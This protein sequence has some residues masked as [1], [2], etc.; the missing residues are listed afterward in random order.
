MVGRI[1]VLALIARASFAGAGLD[2]L[3]RSFESPPEDSRMMMRWWWFGPAVTPDELERELRAMKEAGIGGVEIQ[4]VYPL[5]VDNA[6]SKLRNLP[7]LSPEFLEML[8]FAAGKAKELGLRADLTLGSGWP[9]GGPHISLAESAR[10]LRVEKLPGGA[11][12]EGE[13][14]VADFPDQGLRFIDS[15]LRMMVKR[16]SV[17]AEGLVLDHYSKA[18]TSK[19]LAVIGERLLSVLGP[20]PPYAVFCDS[21]EVFGSDWTPALLDEFQRRRGYDLR[22]LLPSLVGELNEESG[23]VRNDWAKTLAELAEENFLEVGEDW[24]RRHKTLWRVQVYGTPPVTLASQRLVDLADG[25]KAQWRQLTPSRWASS[26]NHILGRPVTATETWTWLHSPSFAATPLDMKAEADRHFLQGVNQLIGH[27]WPYSPQSTGKPGWSLY[28]AAVFNDSNPWWN[29]MPDVALYMRRLSW[30]MR[31]GKPVNDVALFLPVADIRARF[32]AGSGQVSLDRG[33]TA[34]MGAD[35]IPQ[36]LEAGFGFDMVD[37]GLLEQALAS[38]GYRIVVLP[39]VERMEPSSYRRLEKFKQQGG[40]VVA[41]GSKPALAAGLPEWEKNTAE[42]RSIS[43]H[44]FDGKRGVFVADDRR[45]GAALSAALQPDVILD[46]PSAD[47]GFTHRRVGEEEVYFLANTG[48][49]AYSGRVNFRQADL[50]SEWWDPKSGRAIP[51]GETFTLPPYGSVVVVR[52]KRAQPVSAPPCTTAAELE[53]S[54]GW[55]VEFEGIGRSLTVDTLR[56]WTDDPKTKYFSGIATYEKEVTVSYELAAKEE[57]LLE[58]GEGRPTSGPAKPDGMRAWLDAPVRDAAVV[59]INGK[60]AGTVWAPPYRLS[61]TGLL[62]EGK[63]TIRISVANT[64]LNRLAET[65]E[66]DYRAVH[67]RYG[68]RFQMQDMKNMKPE[69][70][71]LLGPVRL[72]AW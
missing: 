29:V 24:A 44:L 23:A 47:L 55:R 66:P 64:A 57:V 15:P 67:A 30:L 63:N 26:A 16:A 70:S 20:M 65:G 60:R 54:S 8:R 40:I 7:Y 38:G 21:L 11:V 51:V 10:R 1:C 72:V 41:A 3:R 49:R 2:D 34:V 17:G 46:P 33:A 50:R 45:L 25:E 13:R 32:T 61:V 53:I 22:P 5:A 12:R 58:F 36:I 62:H 48:N 35:V 19:H 71:G 9:Y 59:T 39:H 56:S 37:D 27:G 14:L 6:D 28:A 31:Q 42:V 69:P 4:P 43:A 52:S 68:E 18:A